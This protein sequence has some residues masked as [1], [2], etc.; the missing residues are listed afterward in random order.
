[1]YLA[2]V[3]IRLRVYGTVSIRS[4]RTWSFLLEY[5]FGHVAWKRLIAALRNYCYE[6][7]TN[8]CQ[9]IIFNDENKNAINFIDCLSTQDIHDV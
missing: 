5:R 3:P 6:P 8:Y 7:A 9:P 4:W 1:M 2:A